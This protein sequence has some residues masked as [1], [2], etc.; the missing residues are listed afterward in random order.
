MTGGDM[1]HHASSVLSVA[2]VLGLALAGCANGPQSSGNA[3]L[4]DSQ[5]CIDQRVSMVNSMAGD[6][7]RSWIGRPATHQEH[8]SGVRLFAYQKTK[9]Q[10]SCD[11]LKK[12]IAEMGEAKQALAGGPLPGVTAERNNMVKAMTED[13]RGQLERQK[14]KKGC[15]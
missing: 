4:D 10:L 6:P 9:D 12:G 15:A 14:K 8:Q 13:V 7:G 1:I 3:C 11:E 2:M 5:G